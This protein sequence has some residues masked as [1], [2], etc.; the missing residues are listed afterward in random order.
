M[1]VGQYVVVG[2]AIGGVTVAEAVAAAGVWV[3]VTDTTGLGLTVALM[4]AV[5]EE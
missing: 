2:D 1:F 5:T 3:V 4:E